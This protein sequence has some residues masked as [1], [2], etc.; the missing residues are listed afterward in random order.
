MCCSGCHRLTKGVGTVS[1]WVS[2]VV[3]T[4]KVVENG[5]SLIHPDW[6]CLY[7]ATLFDQGYNWLQ[8]DPQ[9]CLFLYI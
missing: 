2:D 5:V 9:K 8:W 7:G 1:F 3:S 4:F 6:H